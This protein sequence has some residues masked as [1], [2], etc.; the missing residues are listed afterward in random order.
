MYAQQH[1]ARLSGLP[2][3]CFRLECHRGRSHGKGRWHRRLRSM[4]IPSG[5]CTIKWFACRHRLLILNMSQSSPTDFEAGHL[6][7]SADDTIL[8]TGAFGDDADCMQLHFEPHKTSKKMTQAASGLCC[9]CGAT[10]TPQWRSGPRG[11]NTL[12]NGCGIRWRKVRACN[13]ARIGALR[14]L[15]TAGADSSKFSASILRVGW[16]HRAGSDSGNLVLRV[17]RNSVGSVSS[18]DMRPV[19]LVRSLRYI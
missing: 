19:G 3:L 9:V 8:N 18:A 5:P 7:P 6:L 16:A 12:C 13:R 2:L 14:R 11:L 4:A 15:C 17:H 1:R 10:E